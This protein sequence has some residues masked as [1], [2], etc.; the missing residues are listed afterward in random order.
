[1]KAND[2]FFKKNNEK[3]LIATLGNSDGKSVNISTDDG[4]FKLRLVSPD[5]KGALP[6]RVKM[7]DNVY[8]LGSFPDGICVKSNEYYSSLS[9]S[10]YNKSY[11]YDITN[12]NMNLIATV[13]CSV[14]DGYYIKEQNLYVLI[15][16]NR[17]ATT[18]QVTRD[19]RLYISFNGYDWKESNIGEI[20]DI[21]YKDGKVSVL[22]R[23]LTHYDSSTHIN[24]Y[25][26]FL[27]S[28]E[29][30]NIRLIKKLLDSLFYEDGAVSREYEYVITDFEG[31][32][33]YHTENGQYFI[34]R[35][36]S[37]SLKKISKN[38]IPAINSTKKNKYTEKYF[39]YTK[40]ISS[41]EHIVTA[42]SYTFNVVDNRLVLTVYKNGERQNMY[43]FTMKAVFSDTVFFQFNEELYPS[44]EGLSVN[45]SNHYYYLACG[46]I[47][48]EIGD[49]PAFY[50]SRIDGKA[51][52]V[53]YR[54]KQI[55]IINSNGIVEKSIMADGNTERYIDINV[56]CTAI[57]YTA[58]ETNIEAGT[59]TI[60][61]F[62]TM[63]SNYIAE[64]SYRVLATGFTIT[65]GNFTIS[66]KA[67]Q[68][69][70]LCSEGESPNYAKAIRFVDNDV[71]YS[72]STPDF[73]TGSPNYNFYGNGSTG[74]A[75]VYKAKGRYGNYINVTSYNVTV[76]GGISFL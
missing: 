22:T 73:V 68:R 28:I 60:E 35:Y 54:D 75:K 66:M 74:F 5:S 14:V 38:E 67:G 3:Q 12:N 33:Y 21:M 32:R 76:S 52:A 58:K 34:N 50:C 13:P 40:L 37:V 48:I 24:H 20:Y 31:N 19:S 36:D 47:I 53:I 11:I 26:I 42:D 55:Q 27:Y 2:I 7:K 16:Y 59:Y 57:D 9:F 72:G 62:F 63:L 10:D 15:G 65:D 41:I 29:D 18:W 25:D 61:N 6:I 71:D 30:T 8:A 46:T 70:W 23:K 51:R 39:D 17:S 64:N 43:G 1:M 4:I 45:F 56:F 69:I 49:T 44:R